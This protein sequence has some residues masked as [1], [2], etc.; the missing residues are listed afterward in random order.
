M[1]RLTLRVRGVRV[2]WWVPLAALEQALALALKLAPLIISL[3]PA[4]K[5]ARLR[6]YW[7]PDGRTLL[8]SLL[9][10]KPF[11]RLP[12]GEPLLVIETPDFALELREV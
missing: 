2:R 8:A 3:V 5:T 1:M 7:Q 11:L 6:R 9:D 12:P 10:D 4:N